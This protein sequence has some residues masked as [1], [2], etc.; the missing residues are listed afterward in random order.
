[1][2]ERD[3]RRRLVITVVG[4]T[5]SGKTTWCVTECDNYNGGRVT[6][7]DYQQARNLAKYPTMPMSYVDKQRKG[8]YR[9][10]NHDWKKFT[11][12]C[13]KAYQRNDMKGL[14]YYDDASTYMLSNEFKPLT[15]LMGGVRHKGC[16]IITTH[17]QLW[18]VP[19]YIMNNT[20]IL[21]LFKTGEAADKGDPKRF[22]HYD[23]IQEAFNRVSANSNK[24]Y[25][26]IVKLYGINNE[27]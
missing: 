13:V 14:I 19:P 4:E 16:D 11:E 7:L 5:E 9:V 18:S 10:V 26:E 6:I 3:T 24:H 12:L 8:I 22:K 17:H 2:S 23:R 15:D 27:I 25:H 20:Q 21:V 1:M